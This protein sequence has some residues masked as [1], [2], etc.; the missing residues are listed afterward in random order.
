MCEYE[1]EPGRYEAVFRL[2]CIVFQG[3]TEESIILIND[4]TLI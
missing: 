3:F 4:N 1:R 2:D